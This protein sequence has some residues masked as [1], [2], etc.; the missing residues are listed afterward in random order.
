MPYAVIYI[1]E[2]AKA[3]QPAAAETL[4]QCAYCFSP[5]LEDTGPGVCTLD[6]KGLAVPEADWEKWAAKIIDMLAQVVGRAQIG[7]ART[8][9][10]AAQAARQAHPFLRVA[11]VEEFLADLPVAQWGFGEDILEILESWGIRTVGAFLALGRDKI[12]ERLGVEAVEMFDLA[13]QSRPLKLITPPET[14]AETME[15]ETHLE[16]L[17]SL[18]FV[19]RRFIEQL[20]RRLEMVYRVAGEIHLRL[21]LA[22]GAA[23][24][25]L[26]VIPAPTRDV[27]TLFR[28]LQT[29]LENVRT[30]APICSLRLAAKPARAGTYQF[31]LFEVAL[32]DPNQFHET[33]ARLTA[34]LGPNRVGTPRL[35]D[36]HRPDSFTMEL[37]G[38]A[39]GAASAQEEEEDKTS[40]SLGLRRF[41]PPWLAR[42]EVREARP[43]LLG[44]SS[45]SGPIAHAL[46][47]WRLSGQWWDA[48]NWEREEW[49]V[50]TSD[51]ELFR[52]VRQNEQWSVEGVFD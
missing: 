22:S 52:L 31:G 2:W 16:S 23:Y 40:H 41:R 3:G 13:G 24:E 17:E 39:N 8:P 4:W 6:L 43:V 10:L 1:P 5:R 11:N 18:L 35:A 15:F 14:F 25:R 20:A 48:Q 37:D 45:F 30:D 19:L 34:L 51:G 50:Q 26:F 7:V 36:T 47:P 38:L 21:G 27:E 12:A 33:L 32:R 9:H 29:H 28:L 49:D 42:V 46:G 44:S